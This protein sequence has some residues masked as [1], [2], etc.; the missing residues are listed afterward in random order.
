MIEIYMI[1]YGKKIINE[2]M[3]NFEV[4]FLKKMTSFFFKKKNKYFGIY[5]KT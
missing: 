1:M 4:K 5:T 2:I 3:L